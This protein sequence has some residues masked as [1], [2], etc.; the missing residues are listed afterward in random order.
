MNKARLLVIFTVLTLLFSCEYEQ[1]FVYCPDCKTSIPENAMLTIKLEGFNYP[2]NIEVY[3]GILEDGV[4]FKFL[5]TNSLETSVEVPVNK[6]YTIIAIY[7]DEGTTYI[8]VDSAYPRVGYSEDQ[9]DDPCYYTYDTSVN[10][11]LKYK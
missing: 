1:L 6:K 9:C 10:L 2:I 8:A 4:L 3:E 5:T 11:K 7:P